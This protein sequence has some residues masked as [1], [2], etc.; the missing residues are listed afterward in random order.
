MSPDD[1][2]PP[3][4][5]RVDQYA[6]LVRKRNLQPSKSRYTHDYRSPEGSESDFEHLPKKFLKLMNFDVD[7]VTRMAEKKYSLPPEQFVR[8]F[9]RTFRKWLAANYAL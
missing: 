9:S 6:T 7:E 5:Q 1:P 4:K 8:R 3:S 2:P